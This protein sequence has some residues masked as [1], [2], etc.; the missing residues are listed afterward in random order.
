MFRSVRG[1]L[2]FANVMS[3]TAVFIALGGTGYAAVSLSRNSVGAREIKTGAVRS[4]EV[5]N[6]SLTANDLAR[7][8][9]RA[10]PAGPAGPAGAAGAAG[11]RGPTGATGPRGAD[12]VAGTDGTDGTDGSDGTAVAFARV[13]G[14][15]TLIGG[16]AQSK[17]IAQSMIQHDAGASTASTTGAGVYCFGGLG[18][19]PTSVSVSVDNTDAMPATGSLT[20]GAINFVASAAIFKGEDLGYCDATHG[21]ARVAIMKV[22]EA[23]APTLTNHGFFIWFEG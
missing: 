4:S 8:V 14:N 21:Q 6:R 17:N 20:G 9:L 1:R 11:A 22:D 23:T 3:A 19:T 7:N 5:K 10:G 12:G 18:F 15:G 2:T 13:D 16:A